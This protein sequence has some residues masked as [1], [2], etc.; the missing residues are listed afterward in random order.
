MASCCFFFLVANEVTEAG[1]GPVA[2]RLIT[3]M[4]A[5]AAVDLTI[6]EGWREEVEAEEVGDG[7]RYGGNGPSNP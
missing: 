4:A 3:G 2:G 1:G 6:T 5:A 7:G